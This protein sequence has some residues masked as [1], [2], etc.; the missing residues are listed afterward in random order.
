MPEGM[1][2]T[3]K[4]LISELGLGRHAI[5]NLV[6]SG[7]LKSLW[8]GVYARGNVQISWQGIVYALQAIEETDLI[9][10]GLSALELRGFSHYLPVSARKQTIHLYGNDKLPKWVNELSPKIDFVRHTR[11]EIF[12]DMGAEESMRYTS[13]FAWKE[14][15]G[16]LN[17]SNPERACME[18]LQEVPDH[19]SFEH[20]DQLIQGMTTLSPRTL[21]KL[22]EAATSIKVKRLLLWF[23][24]RQNYSW[25][26]RLSTETVELGSGN[27]VVAKAGKLDRE[28]KITIPKNLED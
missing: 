14:G 21:Q 26:S 25:F 24:K 13:P 8:K 16:A 19:I 28:Y 22:L 17:I 4:W 10:G 3:R 7:Q 15:L 27:R 20:A 9:V 23:G 5:D 11:N 18:M 6:K 2:V 1:I 12:S